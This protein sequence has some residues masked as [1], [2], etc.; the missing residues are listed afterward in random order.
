[1]TCVY[2]IVTQP[3][4]GARFV[5]FGVTVNMTNRISELQTGCPLPF[6]RVWYMVCPCRRDAELVE[7]A[8]HVEHAQQSTVGEWFAIENDGHAEHDALQSLELIAQRE[9]GFSAVKEFDLPKRVSAQ[10]RHIGRLRRR[11]TLPGVII[12]DARLPAVSYRKRR[13]G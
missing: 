11:Q 3:L 5:K 8:L 12:G 13:S 9:L 2:A 1:M 7:A 4:G 6:G 10:A